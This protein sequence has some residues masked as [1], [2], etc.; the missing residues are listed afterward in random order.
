VYKRQVLQCVLLQHV[1]QV[2]IMP[3]VETS[4]FHC[5]GELYS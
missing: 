2:V 5:V 1:L 3:F 4:L